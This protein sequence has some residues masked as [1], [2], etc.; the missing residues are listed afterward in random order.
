MRALA[1][2]H[3]A[4]CGGILEAANRVDAR[5]GGVD[6]RARPDQGRRA[7]EDVAH[8]AG[9]ALEADELD[10]AR[11]DGAAVR[12]GP[13]IEQAEPGVVRARVRIDPGRAQ[14]VGPQRGDELGRGGR[15]DEAAPL[16][17]DPGQPRVRPERAADR[18]P[19]VR[20]AGVDREDERDPAH[21][22]RRDPARE[23]LDLPERLADERE[24]AEAEVAEPAV[25]ELRG[26]ARRPGGEVAA[27][28]ERD[29][30]PVAGRELGDAG[31]EDPAAD[32][33]QVEALAAE[34]FERRLARRGRGAQGRASRTCARS[35]R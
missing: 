25:D 4:A 3:G 7:G 31:A 9:A 28:D 27:L 33:E 15:R 29:R 8:L 20:P 12:S 10:A 34:P 2:R 21:E 18:H 13:E 1:E 22:V 35:S 11:D 17:R 24:V 23:R 6:D 30:E 5:A 19:P 32:D 16:L 26:C 14:P